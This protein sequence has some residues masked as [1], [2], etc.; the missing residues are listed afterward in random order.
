MGNKAV[1]VH[2]KDYAFRAIDQ[3]QTMT[4]VEG[5][6]Y[7]KITFESGQ[8]IPKYIVYTIKPS[9]V[10]KNDKPNFAAATAASGQFRVL[11]EKN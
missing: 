4:A 2:L 8:Q 7:A 9:G 1:L 10:T 11:V 6:S 3:T 5:G